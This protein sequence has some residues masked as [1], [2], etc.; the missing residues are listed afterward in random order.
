[1][2]ILK[3][4]KDNSEVGAFP[5]VVPSAAFTPLA[6]SAPWQAAGGGGYGARVNVPLS[7]VPARWEDVQL[8]NGVDGLR[9][10]WF[11]PP[12][13]GAWGPPV[14]VPVIQQTARPVNVPGAQ[15][16]GNRYGGTLGL[17]ANQQMRLNVLRAQIKQSGTAATQLGQVLQQ[18][19]E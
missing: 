12:S 1:M 13:P 7:Q 8:H 14:Q 17:V 9:S 11:F 10:G 16:F 15:R 2:A 3:R 18:Q 4:R 5:G 6:I 19:S